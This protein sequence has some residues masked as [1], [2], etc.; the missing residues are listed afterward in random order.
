MKK[1]LAVCLLLTAV[2]SFAAELSYD[3]NQYQ[4][5]SR[6]YSELAQQAFDEGDYQR[7]IEYSKK[8][9]ELAAKSYEYIQLM[10]ARS[11]AETQMNRARTRYSW[12]KENGAERKNPEAFARATEALNAGGLA[13]DNEQYD[14]AVVC[15]NQ[16]LDALSVVKG[17]ESQFLTLPSQYTI[18]TFRG[19]KDCLWNIAKNPAVY[20]DPF[21][22][23]I[24][25][26]ANKNKLP[27]PNNP[28][29]VEPGIVLDI[30]AIAGEKRSG[31]YDPK[32][33]YKNLDIKR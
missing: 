2:F 3:N 14:V 19:E 1:I 15:A 28:N 4:R 16:V 12:A 30:P 32:A 33:I 7:S 13:F 21:K 18:R 24:L 8:A 5:E 20:N 17:D 26:E 31:M 22:W 10:L 25:Y 27:D 6:R 11:E 29:W 9:E 23:T